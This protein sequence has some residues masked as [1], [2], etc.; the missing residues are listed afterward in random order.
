MDEALI[1]HVEKGWYPIPAL[2]IIPLEQQ[3][4][5]HGE[6]NPH[7]MSISDINGKILWTRIN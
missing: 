3:E 1:I 2:S 6:I 5:D 4:K 7:I